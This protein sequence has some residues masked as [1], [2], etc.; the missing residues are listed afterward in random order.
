MGW[1][2]FLPAAGFV[3]SLAWGAPDPAV[4]EMRGQPWGSRPDILFLAPQL[5]EEPKGYRK[6]LSAAESRGMSLTDG[7]LPAE[8]FRAMGP[9]PLLSAAGYRL[10]P[11]REVAW[12]TAC[13][14]LAEILAWRK[15]SREQD[16]AEQEPLCAMLCEEVSPEGLERSLGPLLDS[17]ALLF[18]AP[19]TN[20]LPTIVVW[21]DM[22][23]PARVS[24]LAVTADNW[25][26]TLAEVVGLPRPAD[27]SEVSVLPLLTGVGYQQPLDLPVSPP[28]PARAAAPYTELRFYR[29]LP[30]PCPWVP[31]FTDSRLTPSARRFLGT[32]PPLPA[33]AL[34][35]TGPARGLYVRMQARRFALE[36]PEG[37]ACVARVKGRAVFSATAGEKVQPWIFEAPD[38]TALEL[39]FLLPK[40]M[41]PAALPLFA[42]PGGKE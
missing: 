22:V 27:L 30:E 11:V 21:R 31:D 4:L 41:S 15:Q 8:A 9:L 38:E 33:S 39:F 28:Q 40:G 24:S 25:V 14:R 13:T 37:V 5:T 19:Q 29:D 18:I 1:R 3:A 7:A 10:L 12:E 16:G 36:L 35:G 34:Q 26:P 2:G 20:A 17:D 23:W 42:Q 32:L 6:A